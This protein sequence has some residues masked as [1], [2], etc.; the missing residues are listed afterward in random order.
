MIQL[1]LFKMAI[2][3]RTMR[4]SLKS[5]KYKILCPQLVDIHFKLYE[6][7]L[8]KYGFDLKL[9]SECSLQTKELGLRFTNNDLC[10]PV[11]L[12]IGQ[13]LQ[14]L[15]LKDID[16]EHTAVLMVQTGGSCR[17]TN[18]LP[19][20]KK[21]LSEAGYQ[22]IPVWSLSLNYK[23]DN[24]F[25]LTLPILLDLTIAT[26]IGDTLMQCSNRVRPYEKEIGETNRILNEWLAFY[27][28]RLTSSSSFNYF[29]TINDVVHSFDIIP[30]YNNRKP[31]IG[32]VGE[33]YLKYQ[34]AAN[35][36]IAL[37]LESRGCEVELTGLSEFLAYCLSNSIWQKKY[38]AGSLSKSI[39]S[40]FL[41]Q[42]VCCIQRPMRKALKK[43]ERFAAPPHIYDIASLAK[44]SISL[45]NNSGEG[46]YLFADMRTHLINGS[47][48]IA[49]I[50]PFACLANHVLGRGTFK[51]LKRLH[52]DANLIALDYDPGISEVNQDNRLELF[53]A[54][55]KK[56]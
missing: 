29:Q 34:P 22:A 14:A 2:E 40:R 33:I 41:I 37:Y 7:V 30:I 55:A 8:A 52:P 10:Y 18:Y 1:D 50:Q 25:Q 32:I 19:L 21:A 26:I 4:N 24:R 51:E 48:G 27:R 23:S 38:L 42:L 11:V 31:R 28:D 36:D 16:L 39:L 49:C 13:I 6:A 5:P 54:I 3:K 12:M 44:E 56:R 20:I 43:S 9:L 35:R 17:A 47:A 45:C 53:L 46:W 15:S